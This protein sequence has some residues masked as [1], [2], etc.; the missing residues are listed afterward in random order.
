MHHW[1]AKPARLALAAAAA[2]TLALTGCSAINPQETKS[3]VAAV[4][5]VRGEIGPL[6]V[7][8]LVIVSG[9]GSGSGTL[10]PDARG[11]LAGTIFNGSTSPV[12]AEFSTSA[13]STVRV[14]VPRNGEV[15]LGADQAL[16]PIEH[17][18]GIPGGMTTV[19]ISAG[20]SALQ[21]KVPVVDGTLAQYRPLL[22]SPSATGSA[23]PGPASGRPTG[24]ASQPSGP[25]TPTSTATASDTGRPSPSLDIT[26]PAV[27]PS[28]P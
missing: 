23:T 10:S 2:G 21:L 24:P 5:G 13:S 17:T 27:S 8:D 26:Q 18:G 14:T 20:G 12:S 28:S 11:R 1:P 7:E 22:P 3:I 19:T 25:A 4:P 9:G 16:P 6:R 15:M